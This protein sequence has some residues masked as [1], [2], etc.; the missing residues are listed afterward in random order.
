MRHPKIS[1]A[2]LGLPRNAKGQY[3][4]AMRNDPRNEKAHRK[5]QIVG[6]GLELGESFED[7]LLREFA[8]EIGALPRLLFAYPRI[9][10]Q[11]QPHQQNKELILAC[12]LVEIDANSIECD[13]REILEVKWV[14]PREISSFDV[15]PLTKEFVEECEQ[16]YTRYVLESVLQ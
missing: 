16:I 9:K 8:E 15:L 3:L 7:C 14:Y 10:L 6:G 4:L 12:Y 5:W 2:V 1:V 11:R 13:D